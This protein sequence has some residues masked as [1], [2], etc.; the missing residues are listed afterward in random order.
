MTWHL[1]LSNTVNLSIVTNQSS[2][3]KF[4]LG[5]A[6]D[7]PVMHNSLST[8]FAAK[9][10][11][12]NTCLS[13]YCIRVDADCFQTTHMRTYSIQNGLEYKWS[14]N[15]EKSAIIENSEDRG[16]IE[17]RLLPVSY[18]RSHCPAS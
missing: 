12:G 8:Q 16:V 13:Q 10:I 7:I 5:S 9:I 11:K 14:S 4:I 2:Q 3:D 6:Y 17:V 18:M 15:S 1:T